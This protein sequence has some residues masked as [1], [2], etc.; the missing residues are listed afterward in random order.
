MIPIII[1][2]DEVTIVV[3]NEFMSIAHAGCI[4]FKVASIG[5]S[6]YYDALV[7][8]S[9]SLTRLVD[10]IRSNIANAPP[11]STLGTNFY[12]RHTMTT[13]ANMNG[14]TMTNG[15]FAIS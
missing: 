5:L 11:N 7:W 6:S 4:N 15:Y 9:P 8:I 14:I 12:T 2:S 3:K 13:K 10:N 1:F